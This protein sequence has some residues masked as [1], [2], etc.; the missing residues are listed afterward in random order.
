MELSIVVDEREECLPGRTLGLVEPADKKKR[1][2]ADEYFASS[3]PENCARWAV[4][5]S[6]VH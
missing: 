6:S 5:D 4:Y 3:V 2:L 1:D